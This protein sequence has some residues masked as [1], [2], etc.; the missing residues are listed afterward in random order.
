LDVGA[1]DDDPNAEVSIGFDQGGILRC[2]YT[3]WAKIEI[4]APGYRPVQMRLDSRS[5]RV[6]TLKMVK[7]P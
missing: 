4:A 1:L 3:V 5:P 2:S 6:I 7:S